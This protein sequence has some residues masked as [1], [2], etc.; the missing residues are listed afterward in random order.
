MSIWLKNWKMTGWKT[1]ARKNVKNQDLW[2]E[3]ESEAAKHRINWQWVRGHAGNEMNERCDSLAK[4][5]ILKMRQEFN[6][7]QLKT[8]LDE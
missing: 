3:L 8:L 6:S 1:R 4:S 2:E 5:E 7:D